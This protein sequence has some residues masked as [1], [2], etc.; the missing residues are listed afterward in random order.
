MT[1]TI[2]KW[3]ALALCATLTL[4]GC[5]L[6]SVNKANNGGATQQQSAAGSPQ[7]V[8]EYD[9][10][11]VGYDEALQE[12]QLWKSSYE[13]YGYQLTEE[14]DIQQL[15]QQVLDSLVQDRIVQAKAKSMGLTELTDADKK[16]IEDQANAEYEDMISYY[17]DYLQGDTDQERAQILAETGS[18]LDRVKGQAQRLQAS[19]GVKDRIVVSDYLDSVRE[20]ERRVKMASMP[21]E[22]A[23]TIPDAPIGT[24]LRKRR[25][26]WVFRLTT[27]SIGPS[28][29][30]CG[31][32]ANCPG[33][34]VRTVWTTELEP[35]GTS[36]ANRGTVCANR[37]TAKTGGTSRN[38][39]VMTLT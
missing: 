36:C 4:S 27:S 13:A 26:R 34:R 32:H 2:A 24:P 18:I 12:Y 1:K 3:L 9:G 7:V 29:A 37:E 14:S 23:L 8:A 16:S 19:L 25:A 22:R 31:A 5:G 35:I 10:G 39:L 15:K 20:I 28:G 11:T 17:S 6:I 21:D 38:K 30:A 33:F